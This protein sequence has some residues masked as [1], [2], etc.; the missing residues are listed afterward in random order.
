MQSGQKQH[1]IIRRAII[2]AIAI[3]MLLPGTIAEADAV[4]VDYSFD[5]PSLHN[6]SIDGATY[7]FPVI[8]NLPNTN[9]FGRPRLPVRGAE[10]MIPY[11]HKI[12]TIDVSADSRTLVA[13]DIIIVPGGG[14][15]PISFDDNLRRMPRPNR[16]IYASPD[17]YSAERYDKIGLQS[18]RGYNILILKLYPLEYIPALGELYYYPTLRVTVSTAPADKKQTLFRGHARDEES[19]RKHVDN[20]DISTTYLSAEKRGMENFDLLILTLPSL[21]DDFQ[22]LADYHDS[23][24]VATEIRTVTDVLNETGGM[25]SEHIRQYITN[26]YLNDGIEYVL[27]G[28]DD[29]IIKA[30]YLYIEA[31]AYD[32][33][34]IVD[35]K[36][37]SDLYYAC[38]DGTWDYDGDGRYGEPTDGEGGG[39]VDLIAEVYI[40]RAPVDDAGDVARF[41][42]KT[43]TYLSTSDPY[44]NDILFT[45]EQLGYPDMKAYG[46]TMLE[47]LIDGASSNGYETVGIPSDLYS[48]DELYDRDWPGGYW[49]VTEVINR[50][51]AGK[52]FVNHLG[53][54]IYTYALKMHNATAMTLTNTHPTFMY[55]QGC[56]AGGFDTTDTDC[57]GEIVTVRIDGGAFAG[58]FNARYGWVESVAHV[59]TSDGAGQRLHREFWDAVYN[60]EENMPEIGRANQDSKEDNLYRINDG[61]M[62]WT[63][64]QVNLFGDPTVAIK[65]FT[66]LAFDYPDGA[67]QFAVPGQPT[68]VDRQVSG[69][70]GGVPVENSG[71]VHFSINGEEMHIIDMTETAPNIYEAHLPAIDCGDTMRYYFSAEESASGRL[72]DPQPDS[73]IVLLPVTETIVAFEDDFESDKGWTLTG[74]W[75]R[76]IP[77]GQGG[78]KGWPDPTAGCNGPAVLGYNLNGDYEY[79]NPGYWATSPVIDCS[80]LDNV[81]L[82]FRRW[83]GV[84]QIPWDHASIDISVNGTDW[85]PLWSNRGLEQDSSWKEVHFD[86]TD[87]AAFQPTVYL[88]WVMGP[89]N[90]IWTYCGWNLDDVK[91]FSYQCSETVCGD[92]DGDDQISVADAVALINYIFKGG[93]AP[94]PLCVGDANHDSDLNV[95]DAVHII[96]FI[97]KGGPPPNDS[98]C[99]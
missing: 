5:Y 55:V 37:P 21:A 44:L 76:G 12:E 50:I 8:S 72:Y 11:G 16:A 22:T 33:Y 84:E 58:L 14:V 88:R 80:S 47:E 86:I 32:E 75:E 34:T 96:N 17:P 48:I 19:A 35:Y 89:T 66:G 73:A 6:A 3:L 70:Y 52:H 54:C 13:D 85:M 74:D 60:P 45:G 68:S 97:F 30:K 87:I 20:P 57:W 31:D 99:R 23:T 25:T 43:I 98:C 92:A 94:D 56:Y 61:A 65:R 29:N 41:V 18:F 9:E 40:G 77:T 42:N 7:K 4:T 82:I 1:A 49:P 2:A 59:N 10:I 81:H 78:E 67:P 79:Y 69:L 95:G 27:L 36:M 91:V 62:R 24:G 39:D 46:S 38:L 28:D 83:L 63:Y 93:P 64:Y 51:N 15:A 26:R 90:Y 71:Q 53:H